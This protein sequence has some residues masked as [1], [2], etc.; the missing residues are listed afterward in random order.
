M[1]ILVWTVPQDVGTVR[2]LKKFRLT[3]KRELLEKKLYI[4]HDIHKN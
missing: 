2:I 4:A 1:C 3:L